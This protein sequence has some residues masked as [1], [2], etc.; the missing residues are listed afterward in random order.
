MLIPQEDAV[1]D[2]GP[3][4]QEKAVIRRLSAFAY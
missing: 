4:G 3:R 2:L 1:P